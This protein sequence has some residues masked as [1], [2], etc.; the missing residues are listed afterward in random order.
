MIIN[1]YNT[2][3]QQ[4][5]P[6]VKWKTKINLAKTTYQVEGLTEVGIVKVVRDTNTVQPLFYVLF[7]Y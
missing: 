3:S 2:I 6:A 4:G 5:R 1:K 7:P